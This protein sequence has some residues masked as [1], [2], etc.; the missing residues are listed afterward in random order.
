MERKGQMTDNAAIDNV[1]DIRQLLLAA[2][3]ARELHRFCH[4]RPP[5]RPILDDL[6]P[7]AGLNQIV[8]RLLEY[9]EDR[10]LFDELLG[11]LAREN[12]RQ[13]ARHIGPRRVAEHQPPPLPPPDQLPEPGPLPPGSRLPFDRNALFTGRRDTLLALARAL[14]HAAALVLVQGMA[15]VGKTQLAVEFVCRYGRFFRGVHWLNAAQPGAI[16]AEVAACGASMGLLPWSGELPVQVTQ[17]LQAWQASGPRLV[18]L[19]HLEEPALARDWLHLLRSAPAGPAVRLLLT[20]RRAEWPLDLG[21]HNLPL[22]VFTSAE[23]LAFLRRYLP[24]GRASGA[25]LEALA[26]RL[27]HLPLAL[28]LAAR[29]LARR[30]LALPRYLQDLDQALDHRSMRGWCPHLGSPTGHDLDLMQTFAVS[31]QQLN[32][33]DARRLFA[34]AGFCAPNQPIP[35]PLLEA[36]AALD[37]EACDDALDLLAGLGLLQID[38][39][40]AGPTI[41]PLLADYARTLPAG[42]RGEAESAPLPALAGALADLTDEAGETGLP[43]RFAPLRP[44]TE[45]TAAAAQQAGLEEAGTL[46][47]NLGYHLHDVADYQGARAAYERALAIDEGAYGPQHPIVAIR[48]NN[49]GRVLKD[50]GDLAGARAAYERALAIDEQAFGPQHAK[51]AMRVNNLGMVL[52]DLGDLAGARAACERALSI[53]EKELGPGHPNVATSVSNLGLVLH[54][55]GDLAGAQAAYERALAIDEQAFGP[56]HPNVATDLNNLGMVLKDQGDLAGAQAAYER[57]LAIWTTAYGKEHP[58]VATANNNLGLVLKD[59]GDLE[60]ARGAYKRALAIDEQAFGPQHPD[61]AIRV[62]NLGGV[63]KD[64]GDLAGARAAFE[65]AL[66]ILESSSLPPDHPHIASVRDNLDRLD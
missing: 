34:L 9:A 29:Y 32:D 5:F 35:Y 11:E 48:V 37:Q 18:I 55:L 51:V 63:L 65:R 12:P 41:H 14:L 22:G 53:F 7:D 13:Y 61:V 44:H 26:R 27:G 8:D 50:E 40:A 2:F 45:T 19:D 43:A 10:L 4:D 16:P 62:N 64:Q 3:T 59:Q 66:A 25:E 38:E 17:T 20:A 46:W 23:S 47:N 28:L 24:Q 36:A 1:T 42:E 52:H 58:Q 6:G 30:R 21:L 56:Q 39:R 57:A 60:G 33:D 31:W 49:L 54:D 15:G